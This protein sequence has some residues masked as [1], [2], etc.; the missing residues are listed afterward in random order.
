MSITKET[1][2]EYILNTYGHPSLKEPARGWLP[3]PEQCGGNP[4]VFIIY[5]WEIVPGTPPVYVYAIHEQNEDFDGWYWLFGVTAGTEKFM[6][7]EALIKAFK[8]QYPTFK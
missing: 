2:W 3:E 4:N 8:K 7:I 6:T 1:V 5:E